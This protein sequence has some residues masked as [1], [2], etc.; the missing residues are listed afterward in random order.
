MGSILIGSASWTDKTL[1]DCGRF[2]PK[3]CK[4]AEARLRFYATQFPIVEVD[5]SYYGMPT[6]QN[7]L[8]W[9]ER[10][11][12]DFTFNVK[13]FRLFTGHQT[14]PMV[15]GKDI[16][17]AFGPDAPR[18]VYWRDTPREIQ[19]ELWRRFVLALAPLKDAGKLGAVH[20]QF[21]PWLI[22]NRD[23]MA[24][25]RHCVERMEGHTVAVEFRNKSW[26]EGDNLEK[27][28]DFERDLGVVHTMV[29]GP[30]GFTN[31][32]PLVSEA[33]HPKIALLRLHG[34]NKDTWNI[35]AEASSS[36]FNYWYSPEELSAMVPEI[37][38]V[39]S[40][41]DAMHILFNTNYEDQ[42]QANARLMRQLLG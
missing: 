35:K 33:T 14:Q 1:I 32:V 11:P 27:T 39:A 16:A 38:D 10:T 42:G 3:D 9:A 36:R 19:D 2:Y 31:S 17:Q 6:P 20:F 25:V 30:Q 26:F 8:L 29:D 23:G 4:S 7:S 13:A 21:A 22:R 28:I 40:R 15:M 5:S 34:R 41:V 18:Q 12:P 37:R 24:H